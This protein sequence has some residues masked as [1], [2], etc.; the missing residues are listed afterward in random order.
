[1]A[2]N[3]YGSGPN[4]FIRKPFAA[5]LDDLWAKAQAN[6]ANLVRDDKSPQG[7][8]INILACAANDVWELA[9]GTSDN[10]DIKKAEGCQLRRLAPLTGVTPL[11]GESDAALRSRMCG[12]T[13][14]GNQAGNTVLDNL[15]TC[16]YGIAGVT[17]VD[18]NVNETG[19]T[20][21]NGLPPHSYEVVV[22][23]G[24]DQAIAN[25]IFAKHPVGITLH[26][27]TQVDI[28]TQLNC[29]TVSFTRPT[30]VPICLEVVLRAT[31]SDCGCAESDIQVIK[32]A[33]VAMFDEPCPSCRFGVGDDVIYNSLFGIFYSDFDGFGVSSLL[34]N[35]G[36]AD[37]AIA[38]NEFAVLDCDCLSI[39]FE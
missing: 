30:E 3:D 17:C 21:S 34:V 31:S 6:D 20:D 19:N 26:G 32:D 18:I 12:N 5:I 14:N 25:T 15:I 13:D 23:G 38:G 1:M 29:Q 16:L 7:Q 22:Q 9:Q 33:L 39:V 11:E 24:D 36:Q 8:I 4:G 2:C 10:C 28:P 37:I 35:G 27:N